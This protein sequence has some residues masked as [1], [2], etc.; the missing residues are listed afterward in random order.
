M[1][2]QFFFASIILACIG[3]I[4]HFRWIAIWGMIMMIGCLI[5][6]CHGEED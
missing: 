4:F 6:S 1:L 3:T 2:P 5:G